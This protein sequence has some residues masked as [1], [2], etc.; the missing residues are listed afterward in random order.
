MNRDEGFLFPR[1]NRIRLSHEEYKELCKLI[2]ERDNFRCILC[3][4]NYGIHHHH[5][6]FR[7]AY[8]SDISEN[9]ILLCESCHQRWAHGLK[10][11]EFQKQF[12]E[13]LNSPRVVEWTEQH[14]AKI[15][16]ILKGRSL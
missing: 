4:S 13:Y 8:G 3:E 14:R 9:L 7:S 11:K 6:R 10:E 1:E 16:K 2:D 15:D 12:E 5:V